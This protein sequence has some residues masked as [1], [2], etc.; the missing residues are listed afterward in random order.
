MTQKNKE[1]LLLIIDEREMSHDPLYGVS[2]KE[3]LKKTMGQMEEEIAYRQKQLE[4]IKRRLKEED[5]RL[6]ILAEIKAE[7]I[8]L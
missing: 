2:G 3:Q 4:D 1:Y 5:E 7:I 6:L 8:K